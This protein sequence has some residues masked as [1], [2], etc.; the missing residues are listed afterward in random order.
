MVFELC[1]KGTVLN[2]S[3]ES[4]TKPLS[5]P[6]ARDYFQQLILGIEYRMF[7]LLPHTF[8]LLIHLFI[9]STSS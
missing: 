2:V 9:L 6:L 1:E 8:Y 5:L 4:Q 3:M 7:L